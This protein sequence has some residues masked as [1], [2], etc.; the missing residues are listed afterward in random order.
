MNEAQVVWLVGFGA[1]IACGGL[2]VALLAAAIIYVL[3][4]RND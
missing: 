4:F 3:S 1:G 2:G